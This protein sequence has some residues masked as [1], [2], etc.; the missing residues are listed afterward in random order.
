[1]SETEAKKLK[2]QIA[3]LQRREGIIV[4]Y[5]QHLLPRAWQRDIIRDLESGKTVAGIAND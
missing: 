4:Y 3:D 1:M 5:L 2:R